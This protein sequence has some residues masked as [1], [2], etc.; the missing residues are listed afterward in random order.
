MTNFD[1]W[2][3]ASSSSLPEPHDPGNDSLAD[4]GRVVVGVSGSLRNAAVVFAA[5]RLAGR[6]DVPLLAVCAW[7][8]FGGQIASH[9]TPAPALDAAYRDHAADLL[10]GALGSIGPTLNTHGVVVCGLPGPSL[11]AAADRASDL[12]VVGH[13]RSNPIAHA[14]AARVAGYCCRHARCVVLTVPEPDLV[15]YASRVPRRLRV[16]TSRALSD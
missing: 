11:V 6:L 3:G 15:R 14:M 5:S 16:P 2:S 13:G 9:R 4:V 7:Q 12:L 10:H 8:P 1:S